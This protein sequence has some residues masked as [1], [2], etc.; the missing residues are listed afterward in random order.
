MPSSP[1]TPTP[2]QTTQLSRDSSA[3]RHPRPI[4]KRSCP[5]IAG[6]AGR[7]AD[8]ASAVSTVLEIP[9]SRCAGRLGVQ[10]LTG[11]LE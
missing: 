2:C 10:L 3:F 1:L 4:C 7:T 8:G 11:W 5:C 9:V 6:Y